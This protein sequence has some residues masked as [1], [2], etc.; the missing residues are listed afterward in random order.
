[1]TNVYEFPDRKKSPGGIR[2]SVISDLL[3]KG[4]PENIVNEITEIADDLHNSYVEI[5]APFVLS[6]LPDE[7]EQEQLGRILNKL[8]SLRGAYGLLQSEVQYLRI[9]QVLARHGYGTI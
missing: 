2:E 4:V 5:F 9:N 6:S 7:T 8:E 3:A 1:M